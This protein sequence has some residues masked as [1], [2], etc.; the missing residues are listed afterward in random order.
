VAEE[1]RRADISER[2]T[3][4]TLLLGRREDEELLSDISDSASTDDELR[5]ARED[6]K[7]MDAFCPGVFCYGL[8]FHHILFSKALRYPW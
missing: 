5:R 2:K 7:A 8:G 1:A 3:Q 6:C 4:T